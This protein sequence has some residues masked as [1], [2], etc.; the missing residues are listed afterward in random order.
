MI[1]CLKTKEYL[2]RERYYKH[3]ATV[4]YPIKRLGKSNNFISYTI[5]SYAG[6]LIWV[7]GKSLVIKHR[8]TLDYCHGTM[9]YKISSLRLDIK[10][11]FIKGNNKLGDPGST[12]YVLVVNSFNYN[13]GRIYS[14]MTTKRK[15]LF[16]LKE[17]RKLIK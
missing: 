17:I 13:L 5:H 2:Y 4:V 11:K 9:S 1:K 15:A 6:L 7:D 12:D 10:T 3:Y 16:L 14:I 8:D